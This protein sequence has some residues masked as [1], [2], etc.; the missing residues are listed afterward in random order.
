MKNLIA[1]LLSRTTKNRRS[2]KSRNT[3]TREIPIGSEVSVYQLNLDPTLKI[4][5]LL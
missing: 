1:K 5:F 4:H 2:L 3:E